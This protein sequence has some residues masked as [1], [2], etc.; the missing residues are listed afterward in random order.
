MGCR[1]VLC[2][3]ALKQHQPHARPPP[4][5]WGAGRIASEHSYSERGLSFW[6]VGLQSGRKAFGDRAA[7]RCAVTQAFCS[8]YRAQAEQS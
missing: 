8:T 5:S 3:Q 2:S 7:D 4:S 1:M 6:A